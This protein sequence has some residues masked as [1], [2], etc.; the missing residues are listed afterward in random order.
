M[1][2]EIPNI[3]EGENYRDTEHYGFRDICL[4]QV[5]RIMTIYSKELVEGFYKY[6]Q[7]D[8]SGNH[9]VVAYIPD[10]KKSYIQSVQCLSDLLYPK[11]DDETRE[12]IAY[13][14]KEIADEHDKFQEKKETEAVAMTTWL[15]FE[16]PKMREMFQE[17][18]LLLERLGWLQDASLED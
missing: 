13:I 9:Q 14:E 4:R 7:R 8:S 5:Q 6:S 15:K 11:F 1:E 10:G 2:Q 16:V 12:R 18:C 17:L 3:I